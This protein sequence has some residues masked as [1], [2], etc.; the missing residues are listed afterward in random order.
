MENNS[1]MC[2]LEQMREQMQMLRN[3]L[4]RQE[5][6]NDKLVRRAVESGMSWIKRFVYLEFCMLPLLALVWLGIKSFF[7]LSWPNYVFM[8]VMTVADAVWDYRINVASLRIERMEDANLMDT[9]HSLA[10]M[11]R[12]RARS[13][14]IMMPFLVVW[15]VWTGME[16]W[17]NPACRGGGEDLVGSV[18]CGGFWGFF[19]SI[20]LALFAAIHIYRKMQRTNDELIR[21]ISELS[22]D[23]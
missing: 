6:I 15:I 18:A 17:M 1:S 21:Q 23:K 10:R 7:G 3:K 2:E 22:D 5:I 19:L 12:M 9:L 11:K 13:F 20:P 8:V 14:C 16:M 4:D